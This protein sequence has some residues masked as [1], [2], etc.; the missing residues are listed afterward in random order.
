MA[1]EDYH[2]LGAR[3]MWIV[4]VGCS[5]KDAL[6]SYREHAGYNY[7]G[8]MTLEDAE[9]FERLVMQ[10]YAAQ[11]AEGGKAVYGE[12]EVELITILAPRA[13]DLP[14]TWGSPRRAARNWVLT[15]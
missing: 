5:G 15:S 12:I 13:D 14:A 3:G 10:E 4:K 2:H 1:L 9:E 7:Y 8:P 11:L 6:G